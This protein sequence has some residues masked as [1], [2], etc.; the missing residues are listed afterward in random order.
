MDRGYCRF[1]IGGELRAYASATTP[2]DI[3]AGILA[4]LEQHGV[5]REQLAV[6]V[7]IEKLEEDFAAI[8]ARAFERL[9][10]AFDFHG[11][12]IAVIEAYERTGRG[13]VSRKDP[14][15]EHGHLAA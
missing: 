7:D 3:L 14:G 11:L 13:V 2:A 1:T 8:D 9:L 12:Q 10:S 15:T 5:S 4:A 6:S